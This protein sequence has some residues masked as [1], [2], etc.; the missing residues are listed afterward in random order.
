MLLVETCKHPS[1]HI[2]KL[3]FYFFNFLPYI[4]WGVYYIAREENRLWGYFDVDFAQ[5]AND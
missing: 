4:S 5:D 1:W 2:F 3:F